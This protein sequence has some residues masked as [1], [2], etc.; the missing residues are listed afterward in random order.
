MIKLGNLEVF[1]VAMQ[2]GEMACISPSTNK[3]GIL[4]F[5]NLLASATSLA[6]GELLLPKLE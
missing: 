4:V 6:S 1:K 5:T 2:I 3:E